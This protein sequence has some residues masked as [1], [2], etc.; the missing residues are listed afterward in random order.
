MKNILLFAIAISFTAFSFQASAQQVI[1]TA[2]GYYEGENISL[3]YTVGEPVIETYTNGNVILTQGF[4]QPYSFYL[5]QILNIQVGWSGISSYL[6]PLNKGVEGIFAPYQ[7]D[8]V[9]IASMEGVYYPA[10]S[11]NTIGNWDYNTGYKVKAE[12][13]FDLKIT[14]TQIE[15]PAIELAEGWGILPVISRYDV[16]VE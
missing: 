9:I 16:D 11:I 6:D 3:S 12:N 13:Q 4:Q 1:A 2:G 15:N 7:N 14:G 5:S 10:Q 8:L